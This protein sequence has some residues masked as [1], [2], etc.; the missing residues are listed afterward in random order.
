[1]DNKS[2]EKLFIV[3]ATIEANK[4]DYKEKMKNLTQDP[5]GMIATIMDQIKM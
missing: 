5:T 1:M 4:Q 2:D 3:Q